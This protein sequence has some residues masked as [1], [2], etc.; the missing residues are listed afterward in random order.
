MP[1][2]ATQGVGLFARNPLRRA[3]LVCATIVP[4]IV[5]L[6]PAPAIAQVIAG[7]AQLC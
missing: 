3:C 1:R 2:R 4:I 5:G 6:V 7:N